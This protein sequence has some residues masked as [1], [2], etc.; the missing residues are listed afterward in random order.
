MSLLEKKGAVIT[1]G[2][3]GLGLAIAQA[4]ARAGA[5]AVN[6][7]RSIRPADHAVHL[8]KQQGVREADRRVIGRAD[9]SEPLQIK[10]VPVAIPVKIED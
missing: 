2:T 3:R 10:V 8:L 1:G 9:S 4:F 6:A 7:S 5:A